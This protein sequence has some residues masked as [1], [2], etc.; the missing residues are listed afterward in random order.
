MAQ[1]HDDIQHQLKVI[2]SGRSMI[3][4]AEE[5]LQTLLDQLKAQET[6]APPPPEPPRPITEEELQAAV[7]ALRKVGYVPKIKYR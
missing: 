1:I 2:A 4:K 6:G 7:R 3:K 5:R